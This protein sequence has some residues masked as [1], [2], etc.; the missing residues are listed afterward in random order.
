MRAI[1]LRRFRDG[2]GHCATPSSRRAS[3]S[4]A[5]SAAL[6]GRLA[7]ACTP[8]VSASPLADTTVYSVFE[9]WLEL[10]PFGRSCCGELKS[11]W[12]FAKMPNRKPC[13]S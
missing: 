3:G 2:K 9:D 12:G 8:D 11:D 6:V 4:R 7:L 10:L 13:P 1:G 5:G